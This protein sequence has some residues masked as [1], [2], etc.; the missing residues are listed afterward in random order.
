MENNV[1]FFIG[2]NIV[3][4]DKTCIHHSKLAH[5]KNNIEIGVFYET[6][7]KTMFFICSLKQLRATTYYML[8]THAL[9]EV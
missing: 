7:T 2:C 6:F 9:S 8:C 4:N 3:T 5:N 1:S